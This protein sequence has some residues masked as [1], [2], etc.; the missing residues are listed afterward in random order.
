MNERNAEVVEIRT[1]KAEL[2]STLL[3]TSEE[4]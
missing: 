3:V 2:D 4:L 1:A